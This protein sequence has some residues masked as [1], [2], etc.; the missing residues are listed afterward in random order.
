M[1]HSKSSRFDLIRRLATACAFF[2]SLTFM[3]DAGAETVMIT[4]SN[5]G[6]GLEFAK[7]YADKGWTVIATHRRPGIPPTLADLQSRHGDRIRIETLDV[8]DLDQALALQQKLKDVPIDVLLN[9]AGVYNDRS[10]C[11]PG[12]EDCPG[13]WTNQAFGN[14][15]FKLLD[16]IMAVNIKGPLIV[17]E[18]FYPN[19]KAGKLKKLIAISSSN[20]TL[21]GEDQPRPGAMYYRM[22]KAALNR[23]FQIVAASVKADGVTVLMLNPGP[24]ATEHQAYLL[25]RYP[26]MMLKTSFTVGH[27]IET[28]AKATLED[29]GK[30]LRY[31]GEVEPW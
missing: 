4:G 22:S 25:E 11:E 31:D 23:E 30:F 9:N 29:S 19:V 18:V 24:T 12:D 15:D 6:I 28:I 17:S 21:T 27:M 3:I 1:I 14:Q 10:R 16:T 26:E 8:T 13:D 7:Q 5:S 2:A 20:G